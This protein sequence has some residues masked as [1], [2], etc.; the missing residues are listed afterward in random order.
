MIKQ[1]ASIRKYMFPAIL[2]LFALYG[3]NL[4]PEP[5][6]QIVLPD[7]GSLTF[8][9]K[10]NKLIAGTA[11]EKGNSPACRGVFPES[12]V[13]NGFAAAST[14]YQNGCYTDCTYNA[15][16]YLFKKIEFQ[17]PSGENISTLSS[18]YVRCVAGPEFILLFFTVSGRG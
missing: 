8:T 12:E 4:F 1:N 10:E 17:S 6:L 3:V 13:L 16:D 15:C 5:G 2:F 11:T 9:A 14:F 7:S 18:F